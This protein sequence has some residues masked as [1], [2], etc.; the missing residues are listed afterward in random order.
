MIC[1]GFQPP[2]GVDSTDACL[3][4]T[5]PRGKRQWKCFCAHLKGFQLYFSP[6]SVSILLEIS[7]AHDGSS[8][9]SGQHIHKAWDTLICE[10]T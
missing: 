9:H 2:R 1:V 7:I 4:L 5:V 6:V 3:S 10:F 8:F